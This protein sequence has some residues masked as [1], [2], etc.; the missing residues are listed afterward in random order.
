MTRCTV[1]QPWWVSTAS[2]RASH[3]IRLWSTITSRRLSTRSATT[4]P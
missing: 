1:I 2:V 3:S 4:P